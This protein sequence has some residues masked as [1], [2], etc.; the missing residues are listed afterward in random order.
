MSS[1]GSTGSEN[2]LVM[3]AV[4]CHPKIERN[5]ELFRNPPAVFVGDDTRREWPVSGENAVP[6]VPVEPQCVSTY[7]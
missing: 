2:K 6:F 7:S 5:A 3:A 4:N 1:Q